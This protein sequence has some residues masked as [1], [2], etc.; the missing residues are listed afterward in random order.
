ML[1]LAEQII[2]KKL[3]KKQA[4]IINEIA[5]KLPIYL[6]EGNLTSFTDGF[7]P[8]LNIYNIE[9]LLRIHFILT[10]KTSEGGLGVVD[11]IRN[12]AL[13]LRR[14]KA[15]A[16]PRKNVFDGEIK[17][18]VNWRHTIKLRNNYSPTGDTLF[19]CEMRER[20]YDIPE[21]L[22]LKKIL[23]IIYNII[24]EDLGKLIEK[25]KKNKWFKSWSGIDHRKLTLAEEL[26]Q[27]FHKNIHLKRISLE[28][29]K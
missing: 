15:I 2:P 3:S 9:K 21:N 29:I 22:V 7:D 8:D 11:F 26:Y 20:T 25:K 27:I 4:L 10:E 23:Q 18:R 1:N 14:I 12:L 13:K 16:N 24:F 28:D 19:V 6:L 17:G 5:D